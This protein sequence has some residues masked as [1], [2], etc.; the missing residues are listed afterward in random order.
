MK[1][2]TYR[3]TS[4]GADDNFGLEAQQA[5]LQ[6]YA[7]FMGWEI[8][9]DF[10]DVFTGGKLKT[11]RQL[12]RALALM[13]EKDD[14]GNNK[15]DALVVTHQ[16]R[17]A[18]NTADF[19]HL[20][21]TSANEGWAIIA[22]DVNVDTSTA[23]GRMVAKMMAVIGEWERELIGE[24]TKAAMVEAKKRGVKFGR[25]SKLPEGTR[26]R[27]VALAKTKTS[28]EIVRILNEDGTPTSQGKPG[29]WTLASVK[30]IIKTY[31]P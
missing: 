12:Q 31:K 3:R 4:T 1:V 13:A 16:D 10:Q 17:L 27:I 20:M 11:R 14:D 21:R 24:R 7:K 26:Q 9:A 2:I 25:K 29:T 19:I 28:T 6:R 15:V 18:R 22:L 30:Y 5:E 8:I 23:T